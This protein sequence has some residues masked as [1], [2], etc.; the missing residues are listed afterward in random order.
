MKVVLIWHTDLHQTRTSYRL[1]GVAGSKKS[2]LHIL[3]DEAE[4]IEDVFTEEGLVILEEATLNMYDSEKEILNTS[5]QEDRDYL[6]KHT[7]G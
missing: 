2:A 5:K 1:V 7:K 3:M 6:L 4:A